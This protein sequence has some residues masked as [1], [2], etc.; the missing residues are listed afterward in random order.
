L[1]LSCIGKSTDDCIS[2]TY[3]GTNAAKV[4]LTDYVYGVEPI[5][6]VDTKVL[7]Q[8]LQDTISTCEGDCKFIAA[9]FTTQTFDKKSDIPYAIDTLQS[10]AENKS[11]ITSQTS[12]APVMFNAPPGFAISDY[13]ITQGTSLA[14]AP[15]TLVGQESCAIA[16]KARSDCTGFNLN[17]GTN[18]CEFFTSAVSEGYVD[19]KMSF[20]KE[21]IPTGPNNKIYYP[22]TNL[23]N[24]GALCAD[25]V[26]CNSN[27]HRVIDDTTITSFTTAELQSCEY[28]PIRKFDRT[29][30]IVTD[31]LGISN[32]DTNNLFFKTNGTVPHTQ[33]TD[34]G[35]YV[36]TPYIP[37]TPAWT[38]N[39]FFRKE[40]SSDKFK[41]ITGGVLLTVGAK[42]L[43]PFIPLSKNLK[44]EYTRVPEVKYSIRLYDGLEMKIHSYN[45]SYTY[46]I[47]PGKFAIIPCDYVDDGFL[48]QNEQGQFISFNNGTTEEVDSPLK[49][50]EAYNKCIFFIKPSSMTAFMA[51][52]RPSGDYY[53]S[54]MLAQD[55]PVYNAITSLGSYITPS[56]FT[57]YVTERRYKYTGTMNGNKNVG[58]MEDFQAPV[59]YV[60]LATVDPG[61]VAFIGGGGYSGGVVP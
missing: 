37:A 59:Y 18:T 29:N 21:D 50:S 39:V 7:P 35:F 25:V 60:E 14:N 46:T 49:Y 9:D 45:N 22:G 4:S 34:G 58:Y 13:A 11:V 24:Q 43:V 44:H 2:S 23:G 15:T 33:I 3:Q 27:L 57:D 41:I 54:G 47:D 51:Q 38:Q 6:F 61:V 56:Y 42:S 36:L 16:C 19:N 8:G 26:A 1:A 52:Y 17:N 20:R 5:T 28:C 12:D 31:E 53:S 55:N 30:Y 48:F 32:S 40:P 10:T